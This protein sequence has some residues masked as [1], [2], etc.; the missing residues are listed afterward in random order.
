MKNYIKQDPLYS[1]AARTTENDDKPVMKPSLRI[2][3]TSFFHIF[4]F[5]TLFDYVLMTLGTFFSMLSGLI[6]PLM[7]NFLGDIFEVFTERETGIITKQTFDRRIN[8]LLLNFTLL[9]IGSFILIACMITCWSWTGERQAKRMKLIYFNSLLKMGISYFE[10]ND[11]TSGGL[12][13]SVNKDTEDI[14]TVISDH[15]GSFIQYVVIILSCFILAFT[16]N[17]ILTLV[18]L[19][20]IPLVFVT[21]ALTS[22]SANPLVV[23]ERDLFVKA[24]NILENALAAIKTIR[25]FNGEAKEEKKHY[26]CL[27]EANDN[28]S[29]RL[30]WV[31]AIR[32]GLIQFLTLSLFIQGFWFGSI[33]VA[34][35]KLAPGGVVS[36]FYASLLGLT[37]L[38]QLFPRL[39]AMSKA[40]NAIR[41][42]NELL[43]RTSMMNLQHLNGVKLPE[44]KGNIKFNQVSFSYPSRPDVSALRGVTL[45]IPAGKTTVFVGQSGSG[46]STITQLIQK[47]YE[48]SNGL[49][50]LDESELKIIDT[51]WLRQQIGVVSQ[52]PV[53]FDDTIFKNVAYGRADYL[54]VTMDEVIQACKLACIHETIESL[55]NGYEYHLSHMGKNLSGG[56]RQRIAIARALIKDPS[57][58]ILDEATSALD[59]TLDSK[60]QEALENCR[61]NRTTIVVTHHLK[62]IRDTD[63]VY[64]MHEGEIVESGTKSEL[65]NIN[66][67]YS[68]LA[69]EYHLDPK[70]NTNELNN[71][72]FRLKRRF[73]L[74]LPSSA[75]MG[76]MSF[77][78]KVTTTTLKRSQRV[79]K[80]QTRWRQSILDEYSD[81]NNVSVKRTATQRTINDIISYYENMSGEPAETY[82]DSRTSLYDILSY[83]EENIDG[84][85][86]NVIVTNSDESSTTKQPKLNLFKFIRETMDK[87]MLYTIGIFSALINGIVNPAFSFVL[88]NLLNTYSIPNRNELLKNSRILA[89]YV[90]LISVVL[91]VSAFFKYLLLERASER[92]AIRLRHIGFGNVIRQPQSWFDKSENATGKLTT[93]LISDFQTAKSLIGHFVGNVIVE[94]VSII[95]GMIWSLVVGWKLTLVGFGLVPVLLLVSELPKYI[96]QKYD[97]KQKIAIEAA[98]NEFYQAISN[99]RTVYS[100]AVESVMESKFQTA[101]QRPFLIGVKRAFISGLSAGFLEGLTYLTKAIT[102]WYG[103]Q[104]VSQGVY[105]LKTMLTV[106]TLVI[107]CTSSASRILSTIPYYSKCK[108]AIK[109]IQYI[110]NLP[111]VPNDVG[112]RPDNLQGA[113]IF[114]D[115][116]FSYPERPNG[117]IIDGLNLTL[118]PGKSVALIGKSGNGKSTIA[119]LLQRVY[120]PTSGSITLDGEDIK[121]IQ[122][123]WLRE[124]IGIVSQE[125]VLFDMTI[126]ENISYGK[127]D[128]SREEIEMAAKQVNMHDFISS[129][130]RGY[131]TKLGTSGSQLSGGERQRIAIARV[132]LRNPKILILD[133][134]TSAL[135]TKNESLIQE[136]LSKAQQGRTTLVITHRLK[137][138]KNVSKI[139]LVEHGQ[140]VESGTHK[141]LMSLRREYFELLRSDNSYDQ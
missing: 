24:G 96:L 64:V 127:D 139:A 77:A 86:V 5:A 1:D 49:I 131:N 23:K 134:A 111:T 44:I 63:L 122:L 104:L 12:L 124:N 82:S 15:L 110:I 100:L 123:K 62:H 22:R 114:K 94:L 113:I 52:E 138:V 8:S 98:A 50:L 56:Q 48:P 108:Q 28:V 73:T 10:V 90:L 51:T 34:D 37:N 59:L 31:Y 21:I 38:E 119:A 65:L 74:G 79:Q 95:G 121:G 25:A 89:I 125:P 33:L 58:L 75:R 117:K 87:R 57:I 116:N 47:L 29:A 132:F 43:G 17:A 112:V 39:I 137:N 78:H 30:A 41:V 14:K 42:I 84:D 92:W 9:G 136:T 88:S 55:P 54:N 140:I 130:P 60:V 7:S 115:V 133:E 126:S 105:D 81:N 53:L 4:R 69:N 91:G 103:A 19:A 36:V 35:K 3:S 18:I 61:K 109:S 11:V 20:S 129:L 141:E 93:M 46:K 27:Q 76:F 68:N 106:W 85:I 32:A 70:R 80:G 135:D 13:T 40:K 118:E 66:G 2:K 72:D 83:Y 71:I 99:I 67:H 107:F 102:F 120:E 16:K 45:N 128:A 101:L 97:S 26:E 6:I